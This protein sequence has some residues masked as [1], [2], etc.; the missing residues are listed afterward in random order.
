VKVS[1]FLGVRL[2]VRNLTRREQRVSVRGTKPPRA[3]SVGPGLEAT[4]DLE[5][6]RPGAY[7]I[8]GEPAGRATLIVSID[9][10]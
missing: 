8:V 5:G 3:L 10:P 6:L 9:E 7:S 1:G 2:V 4:L